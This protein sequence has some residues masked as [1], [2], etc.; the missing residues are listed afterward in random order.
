[1]LEENFQIK[2][3]EKKEYPPIPDGIYQ[4]EFLDINLKDKKG[5]FAK[6]GDK[7]FSCQF[8]LLDGDEDGKTL[9]GRNLWAN[10]VPTS[11]YF[12]KKG[13]NELYQVLE[14]LTGQELSPEQEAKMD[15]NFI[16]G[17]ISKQ[18]KVM[19]MN[20]E[21]DKDGNVYS[22]IVK[23]SPVKTFINALTDKEKED[24]RVKPK[25]KDLDGGTKQEHSD[26]IRMEDIPF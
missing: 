19:V 25:T 22:N 7:V 14:A 1:M 16:T 13:K 23:Y 26:E 20:T 9:R 2:K 17:L 15:S 8:T 10:F 11:L 5:K 6:P 12:G 3:E 24:A 18:C 4:V 21:K